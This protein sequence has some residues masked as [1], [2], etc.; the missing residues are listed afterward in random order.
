MAGPEGRGCRGG[1]TAFR[2]YECFPSPAVSLTLPKRKNIFQK[3]NFQ[4]K[5]I[6]KTS[7]YNLN[8]LLHRKPAAV[9]T[10]I[11]LCHIQPFAVCKVF[12]C[13]LFSLY[14]FF[15]QFPC[16]GFFSAGTAYHILNSFLKR[17]M[18]KKV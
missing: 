3:K 14:P 11:I 1:E 6:L 2:N 5:R 10:E 15:D 9:N 7:L 16:A 13:K 17:C 8:N 4:K 12:I 18:D